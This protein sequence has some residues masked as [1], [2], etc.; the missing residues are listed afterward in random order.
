MKFIS[1]ILNRYITHM[2]HILL[3]AH[4]SIPH[5]T[6]YPQAGYPRI[7]SS[8]TLRTTHLLLSPPLIT[9][10]I[11]AAR[12]YSLPQFKAVNL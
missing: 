9:P 8:P 11:A 1:V 5:N 3:P 4:V 10:L 6:I 7:T 12:R 2:Y